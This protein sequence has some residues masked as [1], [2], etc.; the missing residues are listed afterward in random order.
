M[1]TTMVTTRWPLDWLFK[2]A[3][4]ASLSRAAAPWPTGQSVDNLANDMLV[5]SALLL[6]HCHLEIV[7]R[8]AAKARKSHRHAFV[9]CETFY[10]KS[11]LDRFPRRS[12]YPDRRGGSL[13]L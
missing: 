4:V 7:P 1:M 12:P 2:R 13:R 10:Q 9:V 11:A 3:K 8:H 5:F 6:Q